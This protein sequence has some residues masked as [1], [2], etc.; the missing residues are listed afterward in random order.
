M[1]GWAVISQVTIAL[2]ASSFSSEADCV[3]TLH[4]LAPIDDDDSM[5]PWKVIEI[6]L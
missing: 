1:F 4:V 3:I 5:G 6:K 2:I